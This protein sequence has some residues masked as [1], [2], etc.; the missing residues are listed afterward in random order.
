MGADSVLVFIKEMVPDNRVNL[1][2]AHE[3]ALCFHDVEEKDGDWNADGGV[4]S[5]FDARED[6]HKDT[7]KENDNFQWIDTPE[8]VD[9]VWRS[10]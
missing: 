7:C 2:L 10:D 5:V 8:L 4:D 3:A 1:D 9:S 6:G